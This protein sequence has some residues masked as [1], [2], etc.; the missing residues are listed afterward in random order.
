VRGKYVSASA[1]N[2]LV[3]LHE[4]LSALTLEGRSRHS[5]RAHRRDLEALL[6]SLTGPLEQARPADL[7]G[8]RFRAWTT[9]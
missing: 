3:P 5:I 8:N 2:G 7:P 9:S 1:K 6:A 4:F